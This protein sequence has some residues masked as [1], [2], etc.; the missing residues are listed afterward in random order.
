[1]CTGWLIL[2]GSEMNVF[3]SHHISFYLCGHDHKQ[4]MGTAHKLSPKGS[5]CSPVYKRMPINCLCLARLFLNQIRCLNME[6]SIIVLA[7]TSIP[8]RLPSM[9][10]MMKSI[11]LFHICNLARIISGRGLHQKSA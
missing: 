7:F 5:T 4:L 3:R 6:A 9:F 10:S 8:R 2:V 1:M 11:S